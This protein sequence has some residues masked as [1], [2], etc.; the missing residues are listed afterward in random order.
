MFGL[1]L[2]ISTQQSWWTV[3]FEINYLTKKKKYNK[4]FLR[5]YNG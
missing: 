2:M 3:E 4:Q 1:Y 5:Q